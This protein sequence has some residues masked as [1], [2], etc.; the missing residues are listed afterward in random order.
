MDK[1]LRDRADST[2]SWF[3]DGPIYST[4]KTGKEPTV[5]ALGK[6]PSLLF[7]YTPST[8]S[9][10]SSRVWKEHADVSD[11]ARSRRLS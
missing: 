8:I 9:L 11:Q 1:L 7:W 2:G 10:S 4:F 3:L 6:G 5:C